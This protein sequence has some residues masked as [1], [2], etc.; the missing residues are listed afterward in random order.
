MNAKC[1]LLAAGAIALWAAAPAAHADSPAL[2]TFEG[3][4]TNRDGRVSAAEHTAATQKMFAKMDRDGDG[5]VTAAEMDAAHEAITGKPASASA[6]GATRKIK[7]ID[8]NGDG[9]L[10][11]KEHQAGAKAMFA[12]MDENRDGF[13]SK[14]EWDRGH[15]ALAK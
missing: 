8:A 5:K 11:A 7:A 10:E 4:D 12:K 13:L 2:S 14:S 6:L 3:M 9:I 15:A 1:H